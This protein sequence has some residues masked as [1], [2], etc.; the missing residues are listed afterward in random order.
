M[1]SDGSKSTATIDEN[2]TYCYQC[3]HQRPIVTVGDRTEK[4]GETHDCSKEAQERVDFS[5]N[6]LG[7][8][9]APLNVFP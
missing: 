8:L 1:S 3:G 9:P 6:P 4:C 5:A 2:C 7:V